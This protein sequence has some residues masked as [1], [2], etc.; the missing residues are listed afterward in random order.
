MRASRRAAGAVVALLLASAAGCGDSPTTAPGAHSKSTTSSGPAP[1][2][3]A[4]TDGN[5]DMVPHLPALSRTPAP[6]GATSSSRP[7]SPAG[8][9]FGADVSWP[10][11]PKGMG[12][13]QKRTEGRPMP[14]GAAEFVVLGL[15]NGPSFVANP[16]LEDQVRW[17]QDRH[18]LAA[19]YSLVSYP[20]DATLAEM[21]DQGPF[22]G[23]TRLGALRNVGYQAALYNLDTMRRAG[24]QTPVVWI[25]VEPV[26]GFDWSPDVVANAAVVQGVERGYR[27]A[28]F[29]T[30][31]YSIGSLWAR[32]VGSLRT[33]APEW[34]PAGEG[35]LGE[36][37][38]RCGS[39]WSFGGGPGVLGQWI[40][41]G[42]DRDVTCPG[43]MPDLRQWFHQY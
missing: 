35:G 42:R 13:P 41:D 33:G 34:R 38:R 23:R 11:C 17:V 15:T 20:D 22:P 37:L 36:A 5:G 16:C 25:D 27:D 19:A 2:A 6:T 28:G 7:T 32:V 10:Q 4:T 31:Y 30:G 1:A 26:V 3:T 43:A 18:L 8:R 39:D 40:E 9:T 29:R 12:I 24:L 14:T 21:G